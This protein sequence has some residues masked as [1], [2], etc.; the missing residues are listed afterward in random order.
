[1]VMGPGHIQ[2][3]FI[4]ILRL[5]AHVGPP[6]HNRVVVE[7]KSVGVPLFQFSLR[8]SPSVAEGPLLGGGPLRTALSSFGYY[9][10]LFVGVMMSFCY[11]IF[12]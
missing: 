5:D 1:M 9:H 12:A 11:P 2:F 7:P 6:T 3:V 8:P 10:L 4:V